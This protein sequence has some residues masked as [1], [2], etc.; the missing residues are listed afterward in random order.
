M[1]SLGIA[2]KIH[3]MFSVACSNR[4]GN[5]GERLFL[6]SWAGWTMVRLKLFHFRAEKTEVQ[7]THCHTEMFFR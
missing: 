6:D 5:R 3:E 1:L 4:G 7:R 2:L